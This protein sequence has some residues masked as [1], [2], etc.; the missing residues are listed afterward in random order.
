MKIK[1][2]VREKCSECG[3][4]NRISDEI[5]GCDVC[6]NVIDLNNGYDFL[7]SANFHTDSEN[8]NFQLCSWKCFF[9]L[10]QTIEVDYFLDFPVL[11][12]DTLQKGLTIADF[13]RAVKEI[14]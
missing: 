9:A 7:R 11:S 14:K 6:G 5:Y 3:K 2:V 1:D 4:S 8:E 13:W 10:L 12:A